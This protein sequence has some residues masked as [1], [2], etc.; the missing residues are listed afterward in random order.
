M[1]GDYAAGAARLEAMIAELDAIGSVGLPLAIL[2]AQRARIALCAS[3]SA[4]F[5]RY[6]TIAAQASERLRHP[7]L[8]ARLQQLISDA[9]NAEHPV[10]I[11]LTRGAELGTSQGEPAGGLDTSVFTLLGACRGARQRAL[12]ALELLIGEAQAKG[13]YLFGITP[14]GRLE[15]LAWLAV[16]APND[17]LEDSAEALLKSTQ[18]HEEVETRIEPAVGGPRT[19]SSAPPAE[20]ETGLQPF[21]L[22]S[23]GTL[24]GHASGVVML[25]S[26]NGELLRLPASLLSAVCE[27]LQRAGDLSR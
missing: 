7:G 27:G 19:F 11:E 4:A 18:G 15:V 1:S 6:A 8:A 16:E 25:R 26:A 5:E 20:L 21:L 10:S 2:Y 24:D 14:G 3:D 17:A 23:S 9:R 12:H 22:R 13:G